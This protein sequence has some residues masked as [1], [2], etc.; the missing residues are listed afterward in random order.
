MQVFKLYFRLLRRNWGPILIY[1]AIFIVLMLGIVVPQAARQRAGGYEKKMSKYAIFDYDESKF[2]GYV[3]EFLAENHKTKSISDDK[4]ETIQDELYNTNVDCVIVIKNGF[5]NAFLKGDAADYL[6]IY[7]VPGTTG[8]LLLKQQLNSFL[9]TTDVYVSSG[10]Q[11]DEA[12]EKS[13]S[14]AAISVETELVS[15]DKEKVNYSDTFF[16]Y[17]GWVLIAMCV[18]SLSAILTMLDRKEVKNRIKCS[19]YRFSRMNAEIILGVIITGTV[20]CG[21][22]S[23]VGIFMFPGE[24]LTLKGLLRILNAFCM[25]AVALSLTFLISKVT[26]NK[27]VT[28]LL[29]NVLGLGMAF[30]CGVFVPLEVLGD[31]VIKIARFLP[32]Y[33]YVKAVET[34]SSFRPEKML[35]FFS[36]LGVQLLFAAA[37]LCVGL[38]VAGKKR[39]ITD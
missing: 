28:S 2:S 25:L 37:I 15:R 11:M 19:S 29:S 18:E 1:G 9:L 4:E 31:S 23:L 22:C 35:T 14:A 27:Q 32:V 6:E 26:S 21:I 33:W 34:A 16:S 3:S 39:G 12:A 8:A 24:M 17:L 20:I 13:L 10:I 38:V 30:L 36:Y 5:E 7:D